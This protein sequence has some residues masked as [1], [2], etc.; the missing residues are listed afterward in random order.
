MIVVFI[1]NLVLLTFPVFTD[2]F[3]ARD[4]SLY[5][6][7]PLVR[8]ADALLV[9]DEKAAIPLIAKKL[10]FQRFPCFPLRVIDT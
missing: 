3:V 2:S 4:P 7:C 9:S 10:E 8:A 1:K 5:K 6:F